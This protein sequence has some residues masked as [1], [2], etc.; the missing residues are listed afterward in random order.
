MNTHMTSIPHVLMAAAQLTQVAGDV[1]AGEIMILFG[2]LL[3]GANEASPWEIVEPAL[4]LAEVELR[5][6][7]ATNPTSKAVYNRAAEHYRNYIGGILSGN[8][9][10]LDDELRD[11][12]VRHL[13]G[14]L[15]EWTDSGKR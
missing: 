7:V 2:K 10:S 12:L 11:A 5:V 8:N 14:L 15:F 1:N 13:T 9:K 4:M 3:F 6:G